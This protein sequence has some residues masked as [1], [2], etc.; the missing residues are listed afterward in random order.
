LEA[1]ALLAVALLDAVARETGW[2]VAVAFV[3]A[4]IAIAHR[5]MRREAAGALII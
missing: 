5:S 4:W 1:A 3:V 2:K